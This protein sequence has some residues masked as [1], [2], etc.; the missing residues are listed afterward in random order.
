MPKKL[1]LFI[2]GRWRTGGDNEVIPVINP[3]TEEVVAELCMANAADL[4]EVIV[5][6]ER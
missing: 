1:K 4:D 6:A 5:S 2:N 3:A